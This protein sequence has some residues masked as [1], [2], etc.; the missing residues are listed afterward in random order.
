MNA[1]G[2]AYDPAAETYKKQVTDDPTAYKTKKT[3]RFVEQCLSYTINDLFQIE[4]YTRWA[5]Q[6][7][8]NAK[9]QLGTA[10]K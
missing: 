9:S 7:V 1:A 4:A 3:V 6:Q 8:E 10:G 5:E 2:Q